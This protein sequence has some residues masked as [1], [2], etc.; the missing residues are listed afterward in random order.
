MLR[1]ALVDKL[2]AYGQKAGDLGQQVR[3]RVFGFRQRSTFFI[4]RSSFSVKL[5][6]EHKLVQRKR[7]FQ[8]GGGERSGMVRYALDKVRHRNQQP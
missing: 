2:S 1:G 7:A 8:Q 3:K 5:L 4:D 6:H